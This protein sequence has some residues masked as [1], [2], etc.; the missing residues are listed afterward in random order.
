MHQG[1]ARQRSPARV[2][3]S[4]AHPKS[5]AISDG[6][7]SLLHKGSPESISEGKRPGKDGAWSDIARPAGP[8]GQPERVRPLDAPA[9]IIGELGH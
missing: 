1:S 6:V 8:N 9:V 4:Q 3:L 2:A 7:D 5:R